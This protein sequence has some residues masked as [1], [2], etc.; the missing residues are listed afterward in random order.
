M[1]ALL[2]TKL[3]WIA[4]VLGFFKNKTRLVIEYALI[5]VIVA[6]AGFTFSMW[7]SKERTEKS[8][9]TT[10]NELQTVQQRLGAVESVNRQQ[11][12]TIGE[13]KELRFQDAQALMGLLTDYKVLANNDAHARNRLATLEQANETVRNYLNQRIPPDLAC[14]LNNTCDTGNS[15]S[16]KGGTGSTSRGAGAAVPAGSGSSAGSDKRPH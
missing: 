8:L 5:A 9:L 12:E 1:I 6:A 14:L 13:L 3:P 7:L 10:Q 4:S 11:Q 2:L 16:D 15:G